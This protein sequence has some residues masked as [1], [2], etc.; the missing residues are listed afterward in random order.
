M[1]LRADSQRCFDFKSFVFV[2]N[3][4][5][6]LPHLYNP[7]SELGTMFHNKDVYITAAVAAEGHSGTS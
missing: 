1:A 4:G 5:K 7:T 3:E 2:R 6:W